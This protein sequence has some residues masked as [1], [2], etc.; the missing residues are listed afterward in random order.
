MKILVTGGCGYIGTVLIKKLLKLGHKVIS[1]DKQWFGNYL[2][3]NKNLTN[4]KL[5]IKDIQKISLKGVNTIIHLSSI[6]NDPMAEIDKNLSWETS[7]LGSEI[8]TRHAIKSKVKRI[9]YASSGSVYGI[10]KEKKVTEDLSLKPLSTYNKVKMT[11][12]RVI[13]SYK[14]KIDVI[15]LRPATV[16]GFSPRMRLDLTVNLLTFQALKKKRITVFGGKQKRPN[17]HIDDIIDAYI[18]FIKNKKIRFGIFN[19]GFENLSILQIAKMISKK[20]KSNIMIKKNHNDAR[21]YNLD[22]TKLLKT[23]F[24]PKKNINDAINELKNLY[25]KKKLLD[26][27]NFHSI[28]WLKSILDK[29]SNI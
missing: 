22:S 10:K 20:I 23:G 21:S 13:L 12:E 18:F 11:T 28:K 17:V 16:C 2:P 24:K 1:V 26:K 4:L 19:I 5:D 3:K 7:V 27:P 29:K 25:Y 9:I 6:S 14:D 8:L 15:I